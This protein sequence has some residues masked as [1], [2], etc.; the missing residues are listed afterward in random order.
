MLGLQTDWGLAGFRLRVGSATDRLSEPIGMAVSELSG[1][2]GLASNAESKL[3]GAFLP[4]E[5]PDG[6]TTPKGVTS[7]RPPVVSLC[8]LACALGFLRAFDSNAAAAQIEVW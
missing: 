2:L 5:L 1:A 6:K 7:A 4:F 3:Y 8:L